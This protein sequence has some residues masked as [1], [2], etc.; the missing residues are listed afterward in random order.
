MVRRGE[1]WAPGRVALHRRCEWVLLADAVHRGREGDTQGA[2]AGRRRVPIMEQQRAGVGVTW[3]AGAS[4][5]SI[6]PVC[7]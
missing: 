2:E 7:S 5:A 1:P 3:T 4:I 6:G